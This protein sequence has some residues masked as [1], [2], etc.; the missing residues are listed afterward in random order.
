A[1]AEYFSH[2][3][4]LQALGVGGSETVAGM[5]LTLRHRTTPRVEDEPEGSGATDPQTM[6]SG[7]AVDALPIHLVGPEAD[8]VAIYEQV[9][10]DCTGV[11]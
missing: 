6:L 3:A 5:R 7:C 8:A 10:A 2:P 1:G 9:F 4:P 11:F